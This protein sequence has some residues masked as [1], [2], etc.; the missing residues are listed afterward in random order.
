MPR[1]AF[2]GTVPGTRG[3]ANGLVP[4]TGPTLRKAFSTPDPDFYVFEDFRYGFSFQEIA[5]TA[6]QTTDPINAAPWRMF[7]VDG[8]GDNAHTCLLLDNQTTAQL[9]TA[10]NDADNDENAFQ[11]AYEPLTGDGRWAAEAKLKVND[12]DTCALFFGFHNYKAAGTIAQTAALGGAV[13]GFHVADGASSVAIVATSDN[14]TKTDTSL[15]GTTGGSLADDTFVT[16]SLYHDSINGTKF[17]VNGALAATHTAGQSTL[18]G[19]YAAPTLCLANA[20]AA[21]SNMTVEH[22]GFWIEG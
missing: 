16:L 15:S 14:G 6:G 10:T 19:L 4:S 7:S 5:G 17:Y 13:S 3:L 22:M 9:Y 20:S 8:G 11:Y 18:G 2:A 12:A 1:Q 21:A